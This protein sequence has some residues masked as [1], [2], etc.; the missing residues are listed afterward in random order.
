MKN[1]FERGPLMA[2]ADGG[3]GG[4]AVAK[5]FNV[6]K[7]KT[8]SELRT[9]QLELVRRWR[10]HQVLW[11]PNDNG[12]RLRPDKND[13]EEYLKRRR[14]H[15]GAGMYGSEGAAFAEYMVLETLDADGVLG[16]KNSVTEGR[17]F[18]YEPS[19]LDDILRGTD[20]LVMYTGLDEENERIVY[21]VAVDVTLNPDEAK[22]KQMRDMQRLVGDNL[23]L[24]RLYWYDTRAEEAGEAF[25]APG[26]G[27][28]RALNTTVYVPGE[29]ADAFVSP[30]SDS[31]KAGE[32]LKR[33]GAM[34]IDQQRWQLELEALLLT[35][36]VRLDRAGGIRSTVNRPTRSQVLHELNR[37]MKSGSPEMNDRTYA[38]KALSEVL[39]TIW[40]AWA[41]QPLT[42]SEQAM[43]DKTRLTQDFIQL[44]DD[45]GAEAAE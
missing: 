5:K 15:Q 10:K 8:E 23:N 7:L 41:N 4:G 31:R 21:P 32:A 18:A 20:A 6:K 34:A 25:D 24:S 43:V 35:G 29:L 39:P 36:G 17:A 44:Q 3:M 11:N 13:V 26:E 37:L 12:N 45:M 28:V 14:G 30:S 40:A 38:A 16:G 27:K 19:D 9:E 1:P 2:P 33:V 42:R 22:V